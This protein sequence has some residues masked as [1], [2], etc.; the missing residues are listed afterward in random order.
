M[1]ISFGMD[2]ENRVGGIILRSMAKI[3]AMAGGTI[4]Q[5]VARFEYIFDLQYLYILPSHKYLGYLLKRLK[6]ALS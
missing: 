4:S 6:I 1:H 3:R 5:G 2:L